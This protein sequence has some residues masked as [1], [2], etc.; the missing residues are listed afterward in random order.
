M[1]ILL[2]E[3]DL[4][5]GDLIKNAL[6]LKKYHVQ[7]CR[8]GEEAKGAFLTEH[9]D[10][11]IFD[12]MMPEKDGFTLAQE[13]RVKDK[14]IPIIFLTARTMEEDKL[15]GFS[16]GADDYV[17][18][19]FSMEEL[20]MRIQARLRNVNPVINSQQSTNEVYKIGKYSFNY[21]AQELSFKEESQKLTTK[22][23]HL[24]KL[25]CETTNDILD[26]NFALKTIWLDSNQFTSRSMD[27]YITKLRKYLSNDD[28]I[29]ILN[30]HGKGFKLV[31][32]K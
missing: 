22:E 14:N 2:A 24:L 21:V 9:W 32:N 19:P 27:V 11:C 31:I 25:L 18:K 5:L 29:E 17:T 28:S 7:L 10:I 16:I 15:K 20:L 23:A 12:V 1:K 6:E 4:N 3:D 30:F 13:I 26:R 8:N